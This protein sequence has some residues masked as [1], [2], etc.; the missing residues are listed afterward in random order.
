MPE[1]IIPLFYVYV[2]CKTGVYL[3]RNAVEIIH[4]NSRKSYGSP[5]QL[6]PE[7]FLYRK[8]FQT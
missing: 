8:D 3:C 4:Y 1:N 7:H 2:F 6:Q 5:G